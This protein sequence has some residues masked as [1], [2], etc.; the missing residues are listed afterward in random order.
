MRILLEIKSFLSGTESSVPEFFL[1]DN[2][3]KAFKSARLPS[4]KPLIVSFP[5]VLSD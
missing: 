3:L 5:C 2:P 4:E 1:S